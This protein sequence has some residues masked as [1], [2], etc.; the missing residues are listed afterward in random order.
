[1][2]LQKRTQ[3]PIHSSATITTYSDQSNQIFHIHCNKEINISNSRI[4]INCVS[5][6]SNTFT[7]QTFASHPLQKS[8]VKKGSSNFA[9]PNKKK[10]KPRRIY[11]GI[12]SRKDAGIST[13]CRWIKAGLMRCVGRDRFQHCMEIQAVVMG[14]GRKV[15]LLAI[16][17]VINIHK[18]LGRVEG[19]S[20][21]WID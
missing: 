4:P 12:Y 17:E 3:K 9:K 16:G 10:A 19:L 11:Y 2:L 13:S 6:I 1:M 8:K 21:L 7:R 15:F 5:K 14:N 20:P 18:I